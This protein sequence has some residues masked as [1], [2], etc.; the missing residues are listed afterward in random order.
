MRI[1]VVTS[2]PIQYQA[3]LFRELARRAELDVF[4][5]HRASQADQAAAGFGVGFDWDVDLLSGYQHDFLKNIARKPGPS[6]FTG[7]DTPEIGARLEAGR[8]DALLVTGWHLKSFWQAIRAAKRAKIPVMVRGDSQLGT[9]RGRLK[10]AVKTVA[11]P[12]M[13][14]MFD[15]ALYVGQKSRA[16]YEHYG[17]PSGRLFFSP[18]CVDNDW[19][20]TRATAEARSGLRNQMGIGSVTT[21]VVFAGK[22]I[23][24]KRP[25]DLVRAASHCRLEGR[26]VE[27]AF[28]GSGELENAVRAEAKGLGVPC[29]HLGFCNQTRMPAVYAASDILAVTSE[30]ETWGL[31]ANEALACGKPIIISDASGCA[32]DLAGDRT[33]GRV[34]EVGCIEH[35]S[36]SIGE[37]QDHGCR[38]IDIARKSET[39]SVPAAIN[40]LM[41]A[42]AHI[43]P[44]GTSTI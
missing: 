4:F 5:A 15:A 43:S 8:Y 25:L 27:V 35:L 2:H 39:Y 37:L 33:A 7:C 34:Y 28:A 19:F 11:Y 17:Y 24:L 1:A 30:Q 14:R 38:S 20:A 32:L 12:P 18:H 13:L 10:K 26:D 42:V 3:P 23:P 21:L 41:E 36:R 40:G 22:L 6:H 31:V 9:P 29:H 16:Y 44:T